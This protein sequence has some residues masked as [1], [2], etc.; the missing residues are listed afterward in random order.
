MYESG[1]IAVGDQAREVAAAVLAPPFAP[2]VAPV[3]YA[4][5]LLAVGLLPERIRAQYGYTWTP[6]DQGRLELIRR[7]GRGMRQAMPD[8]LALWPEAR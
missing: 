6:R 8:S 7:L 1:A 2:L 4:N 3:A 5:R